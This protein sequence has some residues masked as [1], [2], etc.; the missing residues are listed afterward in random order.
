M[1][2]VLGIATAIGCLFGQTASNAGVGYFSP[3][4]VRTEF[5][6]AVDMATI[7]AVNGPTHVADS[8][9][10]AEEAGLKINLDIGPLISKP[11]PPENLITSYAAQDGSRKEKA[12]PGMKANKLRDFVPD[13]QIR[14]LLK[15]YLDAIAP[16]KSALYSVFL[17]DE[18][19]LN[20]VSKSELE[21]VSRVVRSVFAENGYP[22]IKIGVIFAGAMF[23]KRFS[24]AA[25]KAALAYVD[26]IDSYAQSEQARIETL[27]RSEAKAARAEF[28]KWKEVINNFR[29]TT[30]DTAGNIFDGGGIPAGFDILAFDLYVSTALLDGAYEDAMSVLASESGISECADFANVKM[31]KFRSTLSFMQ[32]G[33]MSAGDHL[34]DKDNERLTRFYN[35]RVKGTIKLLQDEAMAS[36]YS[37]YETMVI[38]ES[39]SNGFLE[40]AA[41]GSPEA[42]QPEL[43]VKAR[44]VE[45][46]QRAIKLYKE[47]ESGID[48]MLFFTFDDEYDKSINLQ[49]GGVASNPKAIEAISA[50]SDRN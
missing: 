29:L 3:S 31:S 34:R 27:P 49:V 22:E 32:S 24:A 5:A 40:F 16:H 11:R 25:Q 7:N 50:A 43:L 17:V 38:T 12:L 19:Y 41:D 28:D 6:S 39:S 21:R 9:R 14:V 4:G 23:N 20:G 44:V 46:V 26:T 10:V 36:G 33:P 15:P 48:H 35:C 47:P 45:E 13:D 18:P 30:Y 1:R 2:R 42:E 37:K 8:F